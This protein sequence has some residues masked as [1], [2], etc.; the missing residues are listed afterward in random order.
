MSLPV[1]QIYCD[2]CDFLSNTMVTWGNHSY[3]PA[4]GRP[5]PLS[6]APGWCHACSD[7]VPVEKFEDRDRIEGEIGE[8]ERRLMESAP[9]SGGYGRTVFAVPLSSLLQQ[10]QNCFYMGVN[11]LDLGTQCL[12]VERHIGGFQRF[13]AKLGGKWIQFGG[14]IAHPN[15]LSARRRIRR[16]WT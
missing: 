12:A 8:F 5:A 1:E 9:T 4:D 7:I 13:V 10:R 3:R 11:F 14:S 15:S 6:R 2:R 16:S